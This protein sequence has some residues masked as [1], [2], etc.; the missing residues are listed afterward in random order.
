MRDCASVAETHYYYAES[1]QALADAF[2]SIG[3]SLSNLRVSK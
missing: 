1:A 2:D 3:D